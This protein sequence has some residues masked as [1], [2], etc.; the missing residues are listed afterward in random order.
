MIRSDRKKVT[1]EEEKL[2]MCSGGQLS[3]SMLAD[4]YEG[5]EIVED[6]SEIIL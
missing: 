2:L 4:T 6:S 5:K 1:L 3:G